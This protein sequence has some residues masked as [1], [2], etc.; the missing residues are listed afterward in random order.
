[1]ARTGFAFVGLALIVWAA[2]SPGGQD[3]WTGARR[4]QEEFDVRN[5]FMEIPPDEGALVVIRVG[6]PGPRPANGRAIQGNRARIPVSIAVSECSPRLC[7]AARKF[8]REI[9]LPVMLAL[10]EAG[11]LPVGGVSAPRN[12]PKGEER[13]FYPESP[14]GRRR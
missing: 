7:R 3:A 8:A 5:K 13:D 10:E 14:G 1:M 11:Y 2:E 12:H 6:E 9:E 4:L